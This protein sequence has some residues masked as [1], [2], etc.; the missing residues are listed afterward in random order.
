[1][2][3]VTPLYGGSEA[4]VNYRLGLAQHG[5]H[6]DADVQFGYRTDARERPLTWIGEGLGEFGVEGVAAG[7]E[8]TADQFEMAHRLLRGQ[9]IGT[10]E[11]LV[12]PKLA[13][14]ADAKVASAPLVD[15]VRAVAQA[16]GVETVALFNR[17]HAA[18]WGRAERAARIR[19]GL[20]MGRVDEAV[21][22]AEAAGIDPTVVWGEEP[23]AAAEANLW[24]VRPVVDADGNPVRGEDGVPRV[25]TVP[26]RVN[27]GIVGFD[28]SF[29]LPKSMSVLLG[30]CPEDM[31]GGV[32]AVYT[33]AMREAFGWVEQRTS[34][35]KR[36]VH[37]RGQTA[38]RENTSGFMGWAMLHRT[39]RPVGKH[40]HGDPH[41]HVHATVAHM[42]RT[43]DGYWGTIASGGRDLMR[44]VPAMDAVFKAV[45]RAGLRRDYGLEFARSPRTE[46]WEIAG[47]PEATMGRFSKRHQQVS[48]ALAAL[49]YSGGG[50]SAKQARVLTRASRSGKSEASATP[51]QT[52]RQYWR[53]AEIDAG[54]RPDEW[55][56]AVL[57][58]TTRASRSESAA[59]PGA[60]PNSG[61]GPAEGPVVDP[62]LARHGITLEA[63][64]AQL[65][66]PKT[67]LTAYRRRFSQLDALAATARA[68]P[69]GGTVA[70]IEQLTQQVL[71][72]PLF[73]ALPA[74]SAA[75]AVAEAAGLG[76]GMEGR[77]PQL[78]GSHQMAGG[79]QYTTADVPSAEASILARVAA[80][81]AEQ[82]MAVVSERVLEMSVA[83]VEAGQGYPLSREQRDALG[84]LVANGRAVD[85]VLGPPGTGKTTLMRAARVAWE[86]EGYTVAG[87]ATSASATQNLAGEAEINNCRTVAQWLV[88]DQLSEGRGLDGI[89]VLVLDEAS[90]TGDRDRARLYGAC[91]RTGT[92]IVEVG[93]PRQLRSPDCGSMFGYI[94]AALGGAE[95]TENR[96]Q[97]VEDERVAL[98]DYREGRYLQAFQRWAQIGGIIAV[99]TGI[100]T[101]ARMV[102]SWLRA[103]DGAPDPHTLA[104]GLLMLAS[105]NERVTRLNQ[106]TQ[107]ARRA[108]GQ[109]GAGRD[110]AIPHNPP[111]RFHVG[112]LVLL[113]RNDRIGEAVT[114][115]GVLNGYRGVVTAVSRRGV[116]VA[117]HQAGDTPGQQ[118]HRAVLDPSYIAQ[119]GLELGYAMTSHKGQGITVG[120][121]WDRSDGTHNHGTVLVDTLTMNNPAGVVNLSRQ[122]GQVLMFGALSEIENHGQ[123]LE[124]GPAKTAEDLTARV[125]EGLAAQAAATEDNPNDVPVLVDL[126]HAE[127]D[128]SP[129]PETAAPAE[130]V[131]TE[132]E[133]QRV[134]VAAERDA[135]ITAATQR[136]QNNPDARLSEQALTRAIGEHTRRG[137][138][139]R[140]AGAEVNRQ[141]AD[142]AGPVAA[143]DG[144]LVR[145]V[146]NRLTQL[147]HDRDGAHRLGQ[148]DSEIRA[149]EHTMREHRINAGT[150]GRSAE[151]ISKLRPGAR[152]ALREQAHQH[153]QAARAAE[154]RTTVLRAERDHVYTELSAQ[155]RTLGTSYP[156]DPAGL[157]AAL[158]TQLVTAEHTWPDDRAAAQTGDQNAITSL[159]TRAEQT[160]QGARTHDTRLA[161]LLTEQETRRQLPPAQQTLEQHWHAEQ[162]RMA[163]EGSARAH[164]ALDSDPYLPETGPG[165]TP[166]PRPR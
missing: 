75:F 12:T 34:Y 166:G 16:R 56:A 65:A 159:R 67:G 54:G 82:R 41:W 125:A 73:V 126:G 134:R 100:H 165:P 138:E 38:R 124:Q 33:E 157:A 137:D 119:G 78:G 86:A 140:A 147:R 112:D 109:L 146:N 39:A 102:E 142:W 93:D 7:S 150:A 59:G 53:Q 51:D 5:C 161:E 43:P 79:G 63:L 91:A 22:L 1:M 46:E 152:D 83:A 106:V 64:V 136:W 77:K 98:A 21:E 145:Q 115:E 162:T 26:R 131:L 71:S 37:G 40:V 35:V 114:G 45:S 121:Q 61:A 89:D 17:K 27:T 164:A 8:L 85:T 87:A 68:L 47:V 9:H 49:G 156:G 90:L 151:N 24:E 104:E 116:S 36:G 55:M 66:N 69:F 15:A 6:A 70:E 13:V 18:M 20:A 105:T 149:A 94:H 101:V 3:Y 44:H 76:A 60:S 48:K 144:R 120:G 113:R 81:R 10:G 135:A 50:V 72:H 52:L 42:G 153:Q 57:A 127:S 163:Q 107:A 143:G 129:A 29:T 2:A 11:Q 123:R 148:L 108:D 23:L 103:A 97:L 30:F 28:L 74:R 122:K 130:P 158:H 154:T 62:V 118:L 58:G 99:P 88:R 95:L 80:S 155:A 84:V 117:W 31:T 92:K 96:R 25:E 110:Y 141:L 19:G 139:Q 132:G 133:L 128:P 4:Q 14:P 160:H 32:E 111:A